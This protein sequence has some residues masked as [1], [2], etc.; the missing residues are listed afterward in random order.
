M[1]EEKCWQWNDLSRAG[2]KQSEGQTFSYSLKAEMTCWVSLLL[3]LLLHGG[4]HRVDCQPQGS[5][6]GG[7]AE[8]ARLELQASWYSLFISLDLFLYFEIT[9]Y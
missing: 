8:E 2:R 4:Q 5:P 9:E 7:Q 6:A 3:L 1:K